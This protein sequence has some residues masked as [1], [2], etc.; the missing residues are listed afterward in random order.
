M[1]QS[2]VN[3]MHYQLS[4]PGM[5]TAPVGVYAF[6]LLVFGASTAV[7][8]S[9]ST[10]ATGVLQLAC[11]ILLKIPA[12]GAW[13]AL[14]PILGD[15]LRALASAQAIEPDAHGELPPSLIM[16]LS[17]K[18]GAGVVL[19]PDGS[20]KSSRTVGEILEQKKLVVAFLIPA[21]FMTAC[22]PKPSQCQP[23]V[24]AALTAKCT[25]ENNLIACGETDLTNLVPVIV[26][27]VGSLIASAFDP[28]AFVTTLV[29]MGVKDAP[30]VVAAIEDY[31]DGS[32][33]PAVIEK[34]DEALKIAVAQKGLHGKVTVQLK[35]G[36]SRVVVVQ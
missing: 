22:L 2:L 34:L 24:P 29:S 11:R 6:F 4:V 9:K 19:G 3:L 27:L 32:V 17:A 35:N 30:C 28:A 5:P 26:S 23:P 18:K 36:H 15:V 1:W 12:V 7:R 31:L 8:F 16:K 25:L 13:I 20:V 21:L 33:A 10:K 14:L